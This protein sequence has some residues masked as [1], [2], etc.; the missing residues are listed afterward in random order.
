MNPAAKHVETYTSL[1]DK[2]TY[3]TDVEF[4]L[5]LVVCFLFIPLLF[6][7]E[8]EYFNPF[9]FPVQEVNSFF[10]YL[11][12]EIVTLPVF[13]FKWEN[14]WNIYKLWYVVIFF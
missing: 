6:T 8:T 10:C 4:G 11:Q 2:D 14:W 9:L 5:K 13:P 3:K 12:L 1:Y 7:D